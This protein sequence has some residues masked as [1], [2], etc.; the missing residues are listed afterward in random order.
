MID[1][2]GDNPTT[3]KFPP[4]NN[5]LVR[6]GGASPSSRQAT[7]RERR[8]AQIGSGAQSRTGDGQDADGQVFLLARQR[9]LELAGGGS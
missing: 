7:T 6:S 8:N 9:H 4:A 1:I 2:N 5:N 3:P